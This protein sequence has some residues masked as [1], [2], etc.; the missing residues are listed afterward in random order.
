MKDQPTGL[1]AHGSPSD[2]EQPVLQE[3]FDAIFGS[4]VMADAIRDLD[5]RY[6]AL[7][8]GAS[9]RGLHDS[10]VN[11]LG[12]KGP[13]M[14][15]CLHEEHAV[16]IAHG[17][18]KVTGKAMAA[19]AHSNVG[20]MHATMAIFNAWCDR[21][22][23][24]VLGATGPVDASKRRPWI[25]WIHTSRDQGALVR[26]YTK[27][28]DQP[29]SALASREAIFRADWIANTAPKGPVYVNLDA[30]LQEAELSAPSAETP[31]ARFRPPVSAGANEAQLAEVANILSGAKNPVILAGRA[32]R[33]PQAWA[34]R[35]TL[36]E[37]LGARVVT[38]LKIGASFPT[39]HPLHAGAPGIYAVPEAR[40]AIAA[41]DVI[42]SLDWV[43]LGG[44]LD[45]AFQGSAPT[46]KVI[47]ISQDH[48]MHRGWNMDYQALPAI[49]LM[50]SA[51]P[52]QIL[53]GLCKALGVTQTSGI[54]TETKPSPDY[55]ALVAGPII[56]GQLAHAL[57]E[58][59]AR[60]DVSFVHLPLGWDGAFW[61]FRHPLDFLGSDGG[62][63]IGG[64]PG[65]AVGAALALK[66]MDR[67]PVCVGGDG[68]FLMG[69][70][71]IWTAVHY[72]IP[73]LYI[74]G[75]NQSF[76]NDEVHQER[77]ARMRG[78]PVEN[79]WIGMRM[80]DPEISIAGIAEAQ[81]AAGFGP[82][83]SADQL[84]EVFAKALAH[85]EAGGV[86]VVDVRVEPG[87][88]PAMTASLNRH[89]GEKK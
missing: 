21:M 42:L 6:V 28:D 35:V 86:A 50:L 3:R 29:G 38:D 73:L 78:R 77:V 5:I 89:A 45:A 1:Q 56:M 11:Y 4:D 41:A 31:G 51:D 79:K 85:V 15:L 32:S 72:R 76:F 17:W 24:V 36:A 62:G 9:Y 59:T 46:A 53:G 48:M 64:G 63:G 19:I 40:A 58:V 55:P 49:D 14:L 65:I 60:H 43:D 39:D 80:D 71:A 18:A 7:N 75:N 70:T 81:G 54:V 34:Q 68:D 88:T 83:K 10:L 69:V 61:H 23:V 33:D 16:A 57:A 13:Q 66:D 44:T 82:V 22:P 25:E 2:V 84:V 47:Q 27:W 52:D 37:A 26:D 30:G 74:V 67:L 8:P 20:L 87:Y 12:N